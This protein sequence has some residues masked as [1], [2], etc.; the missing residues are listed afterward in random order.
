M[1]FWIQRV[2]SDELLL[3]TREIGERNEIAVEPGRL[4]RGVLP[5]GFP[6]PEAFQDHGE[7]HAG[8]SW[9]KLRF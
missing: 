3:V 2:A 8:R 4:D 1:R 7:A 6:D 9:L 5:A